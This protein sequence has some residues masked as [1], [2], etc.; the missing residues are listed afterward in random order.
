MQRNLYGNGR[1]KNGSLSRAAANSRREVVFDAPKKRS[2]SKSKSPSRSSSLGV[3]ILSSRPNSREAETS[4]KKIAP[5]STASFYEAPKSLLEKQ[6]EQSLSRFPPTRPD[7]EFGAVTEFEVLELDHNEDSRSAEDKTEELQ[8]QAQEIKKEIV[9]Q[10]EDVPPVPQLTDSLLAQLCKDDRDNSEFHVAVFIQASEYFMKKAHASVLDANDIQGTKLYYSCVQAALRM[11][12]MVVKKYTTK[13]SLELELVTCYNIAKILYMETGNLDLADVY[14]NRAIS[15]ASRNNLTKIAVACELLNYQIL[16]AS[17]PKLVE[18]YLMSKCSSYTEKGLKKIA[19]LFALLRA[20]HLVVSL[21]SVGQAILHE[22]GSQAEVDLIVRHIAV[23]YLADLHLYRGSPLIAQQ[24][25]LRLELSKCDMPDPFLAMNHLVQ[26]AALIQS[27]ENEKASQYMQVI[28]KFISKQRKEEW[29]NWKE[30]GSVELQLS[31]ESSELLIP[32][33]LHGLNSD[34]F[35]IMFYFLSGLHF[36]S[37]KSTFRKASKVFTSCLDII[38]LQLQ[39]LTQAIPGTRNFSVSFLT[40]KIVR[41]NYVRYC[42]FFYQIWL[43]FMEKN[44]FTGIKSIQLFINNFDE[45]NFTREELTYYKLLI[46]RYLFLVAIYYQS[47]GDL[48]ASKYYFMRVKICCSSTEVDS[49]DNRVTYLQRRLGIGCESVVA[50]D[51]KS[52]LFTFA[53]LHLLQITEYEI[54][55][56]SSS[57][58]HDAKTKLKKSRIFLGDL[59]QDLSKACDENNREQHGSTN[60]GVTNYLFELSFK[61][62]SCIYRNKGFSNGI[63]DSTFVADIERILARCLRGDYITMLTTFVLYCLSVNLKQKNELLSKL[64]QMVSDGEDNSRMLKIF[65]LRE[66]L[67]KILRTE[68]PEQFDLLQSQIDHLQQKVQEKFEIAKLSTSIFNQD[69]TDDL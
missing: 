28:T 22:L 54:K 32:F 5:A 27:Q 10:D 23:L 33:A 20:T 25:L 58:E 51:D 38:G 17:N 63:P 14:I 8:G 65:L 56:L 47:Q 36:M 48:A 1:R 69:D 16:E 61:N 3:L 9:Q 24:M 66:Q 50:T 15:L 55:S 6:Y 43:L 64:T 30:N 60:S 68:K 11:L 18:P 34:E 44:Q 62:Q 26:F 45:E 53:T 13:L 29:R 37:T 67:S 42:V 57:E 40:S 52:E 21:P 39:E 41:L 2:K 59:Y 4:I 49:S 31:Q 12:I 35:V 46:P 19:D 7:T